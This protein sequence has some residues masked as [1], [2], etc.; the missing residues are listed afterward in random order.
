MEIP[1]NRSAYRR[2]PSPTDSPVDDFGQLLQSG[3]LS[4]TC[5]QPTGLSAKRLGY[6]DHRL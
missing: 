2:F 1:V 3:P 5:G 4:L 6:G